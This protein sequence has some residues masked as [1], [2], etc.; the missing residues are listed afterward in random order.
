MALFLI[1][2]YRH[3]NLVLIKQVIH[4]YIILVYTCVKRIKQGGNIYVQQPSRKQ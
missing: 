4:V 1:N 2:F 3:E